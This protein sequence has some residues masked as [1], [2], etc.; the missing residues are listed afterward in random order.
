MGIEKQYVISIKEKD[1]E[2]WF[3][4]ALDNDCM[5]VG[6]PCWCDYGCGYPYLKTFSSIELAKNWFNKNKR[7]LNREKFNENTLAIREVVYKYKKVELL[8]F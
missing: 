3:Y 2:K 5:S 4:A 1:S 8:R 7:F 6:Y